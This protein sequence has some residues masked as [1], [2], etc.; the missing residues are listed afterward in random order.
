MQKYREFNSYLNTPEPGLQS[1]AMQHCNFESS[2]DALYHRTLVGQV[3]KPN[4]YASFKSHTSGKLIRAFL[5][6][7]VVHADLLF[8]RIMYNSHRH[9]ISDWHA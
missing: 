2:M 7:S 5:Y 1:V 3:E 8:S 9:I 4:S 6:P